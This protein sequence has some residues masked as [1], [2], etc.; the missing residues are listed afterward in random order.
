MFDS[1]LG[2]GAVEWAFR[3][4]EDSRPGA[5][6]RKLSSGEAFVVLSVRGMVSV[7]PARGPSMRLES[8]SCQWY[9]LSTRMPANTPPNGQSDATLT[10][11][12]CGATPLSARTTAGRPALRPSASH[13]RQ[14]APASA[15]ASGPGKDGQ[16][17][18]EGGRN[19]WREGTRQKLAGRERMR[20]IE[21]FRQTGK[22]ARQ[23]D[24]KGGVRAW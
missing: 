2:I 13:A 8:G 4:A 10:A 7:A 3:T 16:K 11:R 14:C 17:C 22:Q 15:D 6:K 19:G 20:L 24:R 5:R 12:W 21:R 18:K 1:G 9:C 23:G